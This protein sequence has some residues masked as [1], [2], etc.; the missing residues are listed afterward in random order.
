MNIQIKK[1]VPL[2]EQTASIICEMIATGE[3]EAGNPVS[4]RQISQQ[5]GVSTSPIKEAL[6]ILEAEGLMYSLPRK[7]TYVSESSAKNMMHILKILSSMEGIAA[8]FAAENATEKDIC[9][10]ET[11]LTSSNEQFHVCIHRAADND[12]LMS[13]L[14]NMKNIEKAVRKV[15]EIGNEIEPHCLYKEHLA[16]LDAIKRHDCTL[17]ERLMVDHVRR[18]GG[19]NH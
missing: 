9:A 3:L 8:F 18:S 15:T 2:R 19:F 4:V 16:I 17:A 12:Y 1:A 11:A 13:L 14:R 6:R 5:L 7:G 10:M